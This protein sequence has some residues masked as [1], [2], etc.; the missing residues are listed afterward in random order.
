MKI[1]CLIIALL[2]LN[3]V[4]FSQADRLSNSQLDLIKNELQSANNINNEQQ[5]IVNKLSDEE[6]SQLVVFN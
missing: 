3:S 2:S 5:D 6:I 4:V 1:K